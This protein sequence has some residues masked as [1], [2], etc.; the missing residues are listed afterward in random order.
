MYTGDVAYITKYYPNILNVLDKFYPSITNPNTNLLSKGL[1]V[2]GGY[3]DYAFLPRDGP[4]TYYNVLYV[5]ALKNAATIAS[6]LNNPTDAKRWLDRA[7]LVSTAVNERRFDTTVGAFFDGNCGFTPCPTHAQ[8]GNS[9]AIISGA[10]NS[11]HAQ[12]AL[13]Y[14]A[15]AHARPYGNSFYDNDALSEGFSQRVYPFMSYFEIQARFMLDSP[16]TALEEI[17]RL[18]GWMASHDPKVTMWEGIGENG[19]L[20]EGKYSSQA[21]GWSTGIVPLMTNNILG[22]TP[23]GP[24]FSSWSIRPVPGDLKWAK[25]VV[26][27]PAGEIKVAWSREGGQFWLS[28]EAPN[29]TKGVIAVPVVKGGGDVFL[30][31]VLVPGSER[32]AEQ[33]GYFVMEVEGGKYVVTVGYNS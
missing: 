20:Y 11:T 18:Y 10:A 12:S 13:D 22:V 23:T 14:L 7:E 31:K 4:V 9:I 6:S 8:D 26:P 33:D 1:G 19:S 28:V 15:S 21:H 30:N 16:T 29:G 17:R 5:L 27:G 3:G 25:G 2:S 32:K 24:G